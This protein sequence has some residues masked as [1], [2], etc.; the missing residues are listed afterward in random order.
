M[1]LIL[2]AIL[3]PVGIAGGI[4]LTVEQVKHKLRAKPGAE[5]FAA[6]WDEGRAMILDEAISYALEGEEEA[7]G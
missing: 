2:T 4:R 7:S 3:N 6:A 5:G 1:G